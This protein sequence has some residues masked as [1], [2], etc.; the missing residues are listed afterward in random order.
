MNILSNLVTLDFK[1]AEN[2]VSMRSDFFNHFFFFITPLGSWYMISILFVCFSILFYF[3]NKKYLVLPLFVSILGS[4]VTAVI[5]K[6]LIDR[7]R[8]GDEFALYIELLSSFPSAHAALVFAL[9]G[10]L[11]YCVWRFNLSLCFKITL[12]IISALIIL[13][14]GFSRVYL[15]VHFVTD[16]IAGYLTGL[17]WVLIAMYISHKTISK[18]C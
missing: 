12:S 7:P 8:P 3:K 17:M 18:S 2:I 14:V 11:I 4:G 9:F 13:L 16:V 5:M 1:I 10:F 6:H 15:G